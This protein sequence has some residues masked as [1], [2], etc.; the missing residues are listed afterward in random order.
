MLFFNLLLKLLPPDLGLNWILKVHPEGV[1]PVS[2]EQ[3]ENG[4][5]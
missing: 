2:E 4:E 1:E 5:D 3:R